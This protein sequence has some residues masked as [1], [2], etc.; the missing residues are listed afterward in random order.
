[1]CENFRLETVRAEQQN[2]PGFQ[3]QALYKYT[4]RL[5]ETT[6]QATGY[7]RRDKYII[8]QYRW[9]SVSCLLPIRGGT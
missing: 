5:W 6:M 7:N 3:L 9:N 1:M 4:T 2:G 8:V